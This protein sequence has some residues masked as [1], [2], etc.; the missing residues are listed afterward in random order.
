MGYMKEHKIQ[1]K[2]ITNEDTE[3]VRQNM[4]AFLKDTEFEI[5]PKNGTIW[6]NI[7]DKKKFFLTINLIKN[8]KELT[9]PTNAQIRWHQIGS[10]ETT[11]DTKK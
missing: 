9:W 2:E 8:K 7:Y 11:K 6:V 3:K 10:E 1:M 5:K 4:L